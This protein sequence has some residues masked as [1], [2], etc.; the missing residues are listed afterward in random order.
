MSTIIDFIDY[1]YT[2]KYGEVYPQTLTYTIT[3][4]NGRVIE[5]LNSKG[6]SCRTQSG[7]FEHF[8]NKYNS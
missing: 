5:V 6:Y 7:V 2:N 4:N 3:T 8:S 1:P